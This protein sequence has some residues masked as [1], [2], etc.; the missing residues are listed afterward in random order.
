MTKVKKDKPRLNT[1]Q[2][3]G[4]QVPPALAR[5]K[6]SQHKI[7]VSSAAPVVIAAYIDYLLAETIEMAMNHA[8]KEKRQ[9]VRV[10][11]ISHAV[12]GDKE[13]NYVMGNIKFSTHNTFARNGPMS[14]GTLLQ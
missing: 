8:V 1:Y 2:K 7:K 13:L 11:D 10:G 12:R 5:K 3:L 4:I 9:R 6:L 14:L